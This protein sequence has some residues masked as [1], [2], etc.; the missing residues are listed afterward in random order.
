MRAVMTGAATLGLFW[1]TPSSAS[2][3]NPE[4]AEGSRDINTVGLFVAPSALSAVPS[5]GQQQE[6]APERSPRA[7]RFAEHQ[8]HPNHFGGLVGVSTH[9]DSGDSGLTLGLD[10]TRQFKRHWGAAFYLEMV[11]SDERNV[12]LAGGLVY[13]PIRGMTLMVTPGIESATREVEEGGDV[14]FEDEYEFLLRFGVGYAIRLTSEAGFGPIVL[15]DRAGD[16]WTSV[17]AIAMGVGF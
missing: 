16:R 3:S 17:V 12:I 11:S 8:Y 15:F 10:Y 6:P 2:D 4:T 1:A 14:K 7:E 9:H 13:Y 5:V